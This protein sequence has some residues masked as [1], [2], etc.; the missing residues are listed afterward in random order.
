M[1]DFVLAILFNFI[2]TFYDFR[3]NLTKMTEAKINMYN[4]LYVA[5][6]EQGNIPVTKVLNVFATSMDITYRTAD[7]NLQAGINFSFSSSVDNLSLMSNLG[8]KEKPIIDFIIQEANE[9]KKVLSKKRF[10]NELLLAAEKFVIGKDKKTLIKI[11]NK[12]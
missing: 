12:I 9:K 11:I 6:A 10:K 7:N 8:I 2:F 5:P 4:F 3:A 1:E